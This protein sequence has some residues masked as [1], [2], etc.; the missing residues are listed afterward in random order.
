MDEKS[1]L[2]WLLANSYRD[3]DIVKIPADIFYKTI[4]E[5]LTGDKIICAGCGD[6]IRTEDIHTGKIYKNVCLRCYELG[7]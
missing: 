1:A 6:A 5:A 3:G 7:L 2:H 4:K